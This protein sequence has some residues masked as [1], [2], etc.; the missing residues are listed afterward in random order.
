MPALDR[1]HSGG[2]SAGFYTG[3]EILDIVIHFAA[4]RSLSSFFYNVVINQCWKE[5][6]VLTFLT[7]LSL[8]ILGFCNDYG[9]L[10]TH[11]LLDGF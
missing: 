2:S 5:C 8:D 10:K 6:Q 9:N 4:I 7:P 1:S 11:I 3:F